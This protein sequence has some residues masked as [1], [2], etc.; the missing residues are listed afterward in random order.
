[1]MNNFKIFGFA[2]LLC[3][4]AQSGFAAD[5]VAPKGLVVA[6]PKNNSVQVKWLAE[7]LSRQKVKKAK[8]A[9]AKFR[10]G[11]KGALWMVYNGRFLSDF[12]TG[13]GFKLDQPLRDFGFLGEHRLF[14]LT[15]KS[16]G[17]CAGVKKYDPGLPKQE[18]KLIFQPICDLPLSNPHLATDGQK[19]IFIYGY[20]RK[21]GLYELFE[22]DGNFSSWQKVF[23]SQQKILAVCADEDYVYASVGRLVF[24]IP[25]SK[26]EEKAKIIF[27]HS[28]QNIDSLALVN[29]KIFYATASGVGVIRKTGAV[30]FMKAEDAQLFSK[31]DALFVV[32]PHSLGILHFTHPDKISAAR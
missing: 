6:L 5:F 14:L 9:D 1:M 17:V 32:L 7:P 23:L 28:R 26:K 3:L 18:Q 12:S 20:D 15:D 16:L 21:G 25:R 22:T 8:I 4:G 10:L 30:E 24:Q 2:L 13:F 29:G 27:S 19:S 31:G 11:P